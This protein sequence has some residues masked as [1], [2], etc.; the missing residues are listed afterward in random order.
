MIPEDGLPQ[1]LVYLINTLTGSTHLSFVTSSKA[2]NAYIITTVETSPT[3][4]AFAATC[5]I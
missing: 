1:R 2:S 5:E 3:L 4:T